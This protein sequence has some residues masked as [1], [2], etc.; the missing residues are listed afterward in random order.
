MRGAFALTSRKF[1]LQGVSYFGSIFLARILAPEVFGIFAI[2]NFVIVFFASFSSAGLGAA[3]IQRKKELEKK[4]LKI[5]FTLQQTLVLAV[6]LIIF[7]ISPFIVSHYHLSADKVWLMRALSLS[8]FLDSLKTIPLILLE[9][10]LKF[11]KLIIPEIIEVI[12]FQTLAVLLAWRGFG[13]WSFVIALLVRSSLGVLVLYWLCPWVPGLAWNFKKAKKLLY[14]GVPYQANSFIAMIKD[15]VMPVFV[16]SVVGAA[17]VGY[18]N[19]ANTYSKVPLTIMS[20]IF[21]ITFPSFARVQQDKKLLKKALEKSLKYTHLF[22]FPAIFILI[23]TIKQIVEIIFTNKWLPA[24][25][26]F[27]IHSL[28]I[29]VVGV[30]NTFMNA[31][32]SLGKVKIAT[33]LMIIYTIINWIVSVPL[34]FLLGFNGAMVGSVVVLLV[35][36]PLNIYYLNKIVKVEILQNIASPFWAGLLSG[37]ASYFLSQKWA[38]NV[39]TL[40][41]I[42]GL[43]GLF[44][45]IFLFVFEGRKLINEGRWIVKKLQAC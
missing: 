6:L 40:L 3:L 25:P 10:R 1:L 23:A 5:V 29:L 17:A 9:R 37:I 22:L 42:L 39:F 30:A 35:S 31:F 38:T 20:D 41:F 34:V 26:A 11:D 19:W 27:Y 28:G 18:L 21:R 14:F 4:D 7:L 32:W 2:V 8:L 44:Y 43:G 36:L 24:L 33:R 16:G 15:A 12:S 45:L 13:V